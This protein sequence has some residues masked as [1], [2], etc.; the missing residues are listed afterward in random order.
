MINAKEMRE[1][2]NTVEYKYTAQVLNKIF[3]ELYKSSTR[4][5]PYVDAT[6][7]TN[8]EN[9]KR[10]LNENGVID[11]NDSFIKHI[12]QNAY[13]VLE[14]LYFYKE[15]YGDTKEQY[16]VTIRADHVFTQLN[17]SITIR[18]ELE[19]LVKDY[20]KKNALFYYKEASKNSEHTYIQFLIQ[21]IEFSIEQKAKQ[22]QY[23]LE[24][25]CDEITSANMKT[26]INDIY[27]TLQKHGY[28]VGVVSKS[29]K[30]GITKKTLKITW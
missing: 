21:D 19:S 12:V 7:I 29:E 30:D 23:E 14:A 13:D 11:A 16:S 20:K 28:E 6:N 18:N 8:K 25:N 10:L 2:A 5:R 4:G 1:K 17:K 27:V 24:Y 15:T 22:G 26:V 3:T 9:M